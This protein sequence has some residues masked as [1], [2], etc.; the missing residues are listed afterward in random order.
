MKPTYIR[1]H[2]YGGKFDGLRSLKV[3]NKLFYV[4]RMT[5]L[6]MNWKSFYAVRT[7]YSIARSD[8]QITWLVYSI[9]TRDI[10]NKLLKKM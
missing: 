5:K 6:C 3:N 7:K 8:S 2:H 10:A 9:A 4:Y 1:C